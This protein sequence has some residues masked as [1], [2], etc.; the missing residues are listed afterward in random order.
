MKLN[1]KPLFTQISE[2]DLVNGEVALQV[3]YHAVA[4]IKLPTNGYGGFIHKDEIK[5]ILTKEK[6]EANCFKV[7]EERE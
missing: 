3:G 1:K 7:K 2:G 4:T 5:S 6:Y